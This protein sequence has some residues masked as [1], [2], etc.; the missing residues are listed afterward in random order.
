M[1]GYGYGRNKTE[2]EHTIEAR[3]GRVKI[4]E[5]TMQ[6][7]DDML[8]FSSGRNGQL[9]VFAFF[10]GPAETRDGT[11]PATGITVYTER[12]RRYADVPVTALAQ[13][14]PTHEAKRTQNLLNVLMRI[15]NVAQPSPPE[16]V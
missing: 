16:M 6:I 12:G 5:M 9:C 10:F 14:V 7:D 2:A 1:S 11:D 15:G 8:P 4:G 13:A 3:V